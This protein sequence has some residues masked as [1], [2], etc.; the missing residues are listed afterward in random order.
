ML[1]DWKC[2]DL[3]RGCNLGVGLL[4]CAD[5]RFFA[6]IPLPTPSGPPSPRGNGF[7]PPRLRR[8]FY[9]RIKMHQKEQKRHSTTAFIGGII[10]AE[11]L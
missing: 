10:I 8:A 11:T 2:K 7:F 9:V 4:H 6:R 3:L 1:D 5:F